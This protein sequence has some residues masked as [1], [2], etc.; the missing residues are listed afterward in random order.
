M[1]TPVQIQPLTYVLGAVSAII[2]LSLYETHAALADDK[3]DATR[4]IS[5]TVEDITFSIPRAYLMTYDRTKEAQSGFRLRIFFPDFAARWPF[6]EMDRRDL[7]VVTNSIDLGVVRQPFVP[8]SKRLERRIN[9][10]MPYTLESYKYGILQFVD[11]VY[12]G[13]R[14]GLRELIAKD[15][16]EEFMI[17]CSDPDLDDTKTGIL[18]FCQYEFNFHGLTGFSQYSF[19]R[20]PYWRS[21]YQN[22]LNILEEAKEHVLSGEIKYGK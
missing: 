5:L 11:P 7:E 9:N 22:T 14:Y 15:G 13:K 17:T 8:V 4:V 20:L 10:N 3:T 12:G 2:L 1:S 19:E 16:N 18:Y 21:I 6:Q